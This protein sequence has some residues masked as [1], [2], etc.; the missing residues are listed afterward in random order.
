MDGACLRTFG[1]GGRESKSILDLA[2]A[3]PVPAGA[4]SLAIQ[5]KAPVGAALQGG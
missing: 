4:V 2:P 5:D 3:L 1:V